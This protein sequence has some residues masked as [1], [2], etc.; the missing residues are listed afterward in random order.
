MPLLPGCSYLELEVTS[1]P[2]LS[3]L[4]SMRL[5]QAGAEIQGTLLPAPPVQGMSSLRQDLHA[6][7]CALVPDRDLILSFFSSQ[8]EQPG[9]AQEHPCPRP[10]FI[11][12]PKSWAKKTLF[13]IWQSNQ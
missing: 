1:A 9:N 7:C 13:L 4:Y 10:V 8:N 11:S 3:P 6:G 12:M 5:L 2:R